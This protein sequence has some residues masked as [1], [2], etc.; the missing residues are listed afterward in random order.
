MREPAE[1]EAEEA[2][3]ARA[4]LVELPFAATTTELMDLLA[5]VQNELSL[6][7]ALEMFA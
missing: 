2:G 6:E 1:A 7:V 4:E 5:P 3:F